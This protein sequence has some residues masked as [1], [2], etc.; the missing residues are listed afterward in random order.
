[1][2]T[3]DL[4]SAFCEQPLSCHT[5]FK[6]DKNNPQNRREMLKFVSKSHSPCDDKSVPPK[7]TWGRKGDFSSQLQAAVH[8]C[9]DATVPGA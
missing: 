3:T 7:A 8:D 5:C 1:M 2:R 4:L 9:M 6:F